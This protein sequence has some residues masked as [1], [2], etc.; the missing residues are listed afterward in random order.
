MSVIGTQQSPIRIVKA[1]SFQINVPEHYLYPNYTGNELN[2]HFDLESK[3]FV[4]EQFEHFMIDRQPW[5]VRK[6]H[7]HDLAEHRIV[8]EHR[9]P[10][11]RAAYEAH[12][13]HTMGT[14]PDEDPDAT[15]PKLVL[16]T[17]FHHD[18]KAP[19]RASAKR[20]NDMLKA[21][22]ESPK[23]KKKGEKLMAGVNPLDFL[24]KREDWGFWYKY[25][26]SLTSEPFSEDVSW[27]VFD[28]ETG[29]LDDDFNYLAG[30]AEQHSR[31]V[32]A[33]DRRFVLRS[34]E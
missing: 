23:A 32:Y 13:V 21:T 3:N 11:H 1:T 20:L 14:C 31:A 19:Q 17:F 26:G 6:I 2:G 28:R 9:P 15:G 34:F 22:V 27:Y 29:V 7:F 4:F 33:L 24:P 12:L 8:D 10:G 25:E 16:G 30:D 5:V 18:A